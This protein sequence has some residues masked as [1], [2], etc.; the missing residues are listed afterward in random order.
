MRWKLN[1]AFG[2]VP[3]LLA[4]TAFAA[5]AAASPVAQ[6]PEV[7]AGSGC[8]AGLQKW[9]DPTTVL[10]GETAQA[11]LIVTTTCPGER[12][13]VDL[14]IVADES[15]S[16][17][18]R[19][20][21][22]IIE[23]TK[24]A[25]ED[26]RTPPSTPNLETPPTP[27]DPG[28]GSELTPGVPGRP[29]AGEPPFC[30]PSG[31]GDAGLPTATPMP[32][33]RTPPPP[34]T[35]PDPGGVGGGTSGPPGVGDRPDIEDEEPSGTVDYVRDEKQ[36]VRDFLNIP[37]VEEDLAS[38][39][40]RIG[41]LSFNERARV[42]INLTDDASRIIGGAN[43]MRGDE[44]T[45]INQ[46]VQQAERLLNGTGSRIGQDRVQIMVILSDFQF[47]QRDMRKPDREIDV[48]T[49]GF[50]VRT[51]DLRK[52]YDLASERSYVLDRRNVMALADLYHDELARYTSV[53]VDQLL[54]RDEL[55]DNMSLVPNT[56][57]PP[58]VTVAGQVITWEIP[59]PPDPLT[60]TYRIEPLEPGTHLT[61]A[62]A[63]ITWTD[64]V[65]KVG[66]ADFPTTTIQVIP[67]TPTPTATYT[68]TPTATPTATATPTPTPGPKYLP[69][70]FNA[71]PEPTPTLTPLPT[72]TVC[73]PEE[74]MVDVA[75][76]IDISTSMSEKTADGV[77]KLNAALDAGAELI[78]LLKDID[79]AAVVGFNSEATLASQLTF[80]K[81]AAIAAVRGLANLQRPGTRIDLGLETAYA[82]MISPRHR[83][84]ASRSIV[85]VTDGRQI[86]SYD[87]VRRIAADIRADGIT[88]ITVGLGDDI[89]EDLLDIYRFI[90]DVIPCGG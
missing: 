13:P 2:L 55:A 6:D 45:R 44:I 73:V 30:N 26:P 68:P 39:L 74:Q 35:E 15:N 58:T 70:A 24:V 32:D 37:Q 52:M 43:R 23:P 87:D 82:E 21:G 42:R 88:L 31:G 1:L 62:S 25:T 69:I 71:W 57:D 33:P 4:I 53:S 27:P 72:P 11:T 54:V 19:R 29:G 7:E 49:I 3:I 18:P 84:D 78:S 90:A 10:L 41:F 89:D 67:P 63:G 86:G 9:L 46:G 51:Y 65:G 36:W 17:T 48:V 56:V 34:P 66:H 80:D 12:L 5:L 79:Q 61:S 40:L 76:V 22:S 16:M 38:G 47:C 77:V 59:Q 14:V 83:E 81:P 85:L 60:L 8:V 50:G 75:E 28:G 20:T 64:T